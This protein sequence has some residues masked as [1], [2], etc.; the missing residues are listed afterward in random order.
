MAKCPKS[1]DCVVASASMNEWQILRIQFELSNGGYIGESSHAYVHWRWSQRND[2]NI[3]LPSLNKAINQSLGRS[4]LW[5][6]RRIYTAARSLIIVDYHVGLSVSRKMEENEVHML[7]PQFTIF[8]CHAVKAGMTH[9][10]P[11][12]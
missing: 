10:F 8:R 2:V 12:A 6:M 7:L 4:W 1:V 9:C 3:T 5:L 11:N